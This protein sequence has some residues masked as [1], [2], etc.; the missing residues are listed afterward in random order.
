M[1]R[2]S[3]NTY[4]SSTIPL[5]MPGFLTNSTLPYSPS[6]PCSCTTNMPRRCRA[7]PKT[8]D[9]VARSIYFTVTATDWP[10]PVPRP[11]KAAGP[12]TSAPSLRTPTGRC[13]YSVSLVMRRKMERMLR[14]NGRREWAAGSCERRRK[15]LR[16][17]RS[18]TSLSYSS[19]LLSFTMFR[20]VIPAQRTP[21]AEDFLNCYGP[22]GEAWV[23]SFV[24]PYKPMGVRT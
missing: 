13:S 9:Q 3:Y 21:K 1:R 22:G 12:L 14:R 20:G 23:V 4:L 17:S 8:D 19:F 11:G 18:L 5:I 6:P 16:H 15:G 10:P 2:S 24:Q 7:R